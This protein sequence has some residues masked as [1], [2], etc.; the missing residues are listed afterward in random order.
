MSWPLAFSDG[1]C[2]RGTHL[3]T[4][5]RAFK[6]RVLMQFVHR[7]DVQTSKDRARSGQQR[8]LK[9]FLR[10]FT[11]GLQTPA[12][13]TDHVQ[14]LDLNISLEKWVNT[15]HR[16]S[17]GHP[18]AI[19]ISASHLV[20]LDVHLSNT[21]GSLQASALGNDWKHPPIMFVNVSK[22]ILRMNQ[23]LSGWWFQTWLLFSIMYGIILPIDELIFF[24]MVIAPPTTHGFMIVLYY[25]LY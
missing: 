13:D 16:P 25:A 22:A 9:L 24:K 23:F 17:G 1:S 3:E 12:L 19:S 7:K 18:G 5:R 8:L 20:C 4:K 15:Y 6:N 2:F 14:L 11:D 21:P 10:T